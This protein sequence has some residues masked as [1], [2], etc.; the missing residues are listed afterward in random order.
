VTPHPPLVA[1][2]AHFEKFPATVKGAFV[3]RS[4]DRDPHQV[5]IRG[6]RVTE[7]SGAGAQPIELQAATL[8]VAPKLD[9]FVPF[10]FPVTELD[11]GW[12]CLETDVD[13]DGVSQIVRPDRRFSIAW[14][15]AT[16]RRGTVPVGEKVEI[17]G[18]PSVLVDRVE[19]SGDSMTV[20]FSAEPAE[21]V[22]W[23]FQADG[24]PIALLDTELDELTGK[25]RVTAYP[26]LKTQRALTIELAHTRGRAAMEILLP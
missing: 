1:I 16:M 12:Y 21:S 19:C 4:A 17:E 14:P 23:R 15:R 13:V 9:F 11:A 5:V 3:L 7:L 25:G 22:G 18:G 20:H 2:R 10:E 8:D 6:A 24:I 26:L